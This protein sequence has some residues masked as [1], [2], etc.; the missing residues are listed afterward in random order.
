MQHYEFLMKAKYHVAVCGRLMHGY[1]E[2]A[3]KRYLTGFIRELAKGV[4]CLIMAVLL[5]ERRLKQLN[6]RNEDHFFNEIGKKY[7]DTQLLDHLKRVLTIA[8][9]H[10]E[11]PIEFSKQGTIIL[12]I[13]GQYRFLRKERLEEFYHTLEEGVRTIS[14]HFRQV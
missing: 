11:S 4:H 2:S 3:H 13:E 8:R 5:Y 9:A 7:F 1:H 10:K 6:R 12:L 14:K